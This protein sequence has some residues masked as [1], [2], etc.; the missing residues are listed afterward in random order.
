MLRAYAR[1]AVGDRVASATT[2]ILP[3]DAAAPVTCRAQ[4]FSNNVVS[5]WFGWCRLTTKG[6]PGPLPPLAGLPACPPPPVSAQPSRGAIAQLSHIAPTDCTSVRRGRASRP[7]RPAQAAK[8]Q[9]RAAEILPTLHP[10]RSS[11]SPRATDT[12]PPR[13]RSPSSRSYRQR[14]SDPS[15]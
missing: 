5:P 8:D 7:I 15:A 3:R 14:N 9:R 2:L 6:A 13:A 4:R 1:A 10:P 11:A 12:S